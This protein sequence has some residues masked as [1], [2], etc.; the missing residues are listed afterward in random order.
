MNIV[1]GLTAT[2]ESQAATYAA[3]D[4]AALRGAG[5]V[6]FPDP[7]GP[8]QQAGNDAGPPAAA[9]TPDPE[10]VR[11][12]RDHGVTVTVGELPEGADLG[13]ALID[14]S[15]QE[16]TAMVVI[17]LRR[18]SPVGKLFLGSTSQRVLLEAGCPV[19][20]VKVRVGPRR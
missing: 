15:Y 10:V 3:I 11:Y 12:A 4:E 9:A 2:P 20:A 5:V 18:R 1:V 13:D 6:L 16:D 19:H 14:A 8:A 17:G 7:A